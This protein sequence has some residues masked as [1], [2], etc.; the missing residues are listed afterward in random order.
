METRRKIQFGALAVVANG[1]LALTLLSPRPALANPCSN[2]NVCV[3]TC[4]T[5]A[6]CQS[7]AQPGCTATGVFC[8]G[9][10]CSPVFETSVCEY[11]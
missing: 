9:L 3:G 11:Q 6:Y 7:I 1:L 8:T 2:Q 10:P 5:V 4:V